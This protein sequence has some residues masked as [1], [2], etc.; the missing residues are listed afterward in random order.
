MNVIVYD[1]KDNTI[2]AHLFFYDSAGVQIGET[3]IPAGGT[4]VTQVPGA[5]KFKFAADGFKDAVID[6]LYDYG[7]ISMELIPAFKWVVPVFIGAAAVYL[8]SRYVKF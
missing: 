5:V 8:L 7:N 4:D 2:R 3:V 6:D 1:D